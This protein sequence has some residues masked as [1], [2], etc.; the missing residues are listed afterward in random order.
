V[1]ESYRHGGLDTEL[2]GALFEGLSMKSAPAGDGKDGELHVFLDRHRLETGRNFRDD[3][4]RALVTSGV[5]VPVVSSAA[6]ARMRGLGPESKHVDNLLLEW[7]LI[8][9]LLRCGR[10]LRCVPLMLGPEE[11]AASGGLVGDLFADLK[12]NPLPDA[13][14]TAT[15]M[16]A[17]RLLKLHGLEPSGDLEKRTVQQTLDELLQFDGIK[18]WDVKTAHSAGAAAGRR[19]ALAAS[20]RADCKSLLVLECVRKVAKTVR[21]AGPGRP[22]DRSTNQDTP[23]PPG[24]AEP[25]GPVAAPARTQT[26]SGEMSAELTQWLREEKLEGLER[27]LQVQGVQSLDDLED[28]TDGI[29]ARMEKAG[30]KPIHVER[31]RKALKKRQPVDRAPPPAPASACCSV[32]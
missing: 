29:I 9:E 14:A 10:L 21:D 2:T 25:L 5:A 17:R 32:S 23:L 15:T 22:F 12:T 18:A 26:A 24:R 1:F 16:E 28:V 11:D 31:L 20:S 7:T 8:L 13:V 27:L 19:G 30:A 4:A 3:F 6:L